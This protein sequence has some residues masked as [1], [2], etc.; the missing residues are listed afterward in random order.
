MV[1]ASHQQKLPVNVI[2]IDGARYHYVAGRFAVS[3]S[4]SAIQSALN[5]YPKKTTGTPTITPTSWL[6]RVLVQE[7]QYC[8]NLN[9]DFDKFQEGISN[10]NP[11]NT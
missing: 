9:C 11:H 6:Q 10:S 7:I 8:M 3:W 2:P 4:V 1:G 5:T